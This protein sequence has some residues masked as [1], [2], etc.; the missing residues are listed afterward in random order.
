MTHVR[1]FELCCDRCGCRLEW[2]KELVAN[3]AGITKGGCGDDL[4][5]EAK[6]LGW[7]V[8]VRTRL[9]NGRPVSI[10]ICPLCWHDSAEPPHWFENKEDS[11]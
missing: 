3:V 4:R 8:K 6:S 11:Q 9:S 1:H 10:D 2:S 7:R 5:K